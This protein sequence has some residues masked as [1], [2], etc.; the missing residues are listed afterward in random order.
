MT[1]FIDKFAENIIYMNL[2]HMLR[3]HSMYTRSEYF[4]I[5]L[6]YYD[7]TLITA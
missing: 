5:I 4:M 2:R 3:A 1:T 7:S 6:Q